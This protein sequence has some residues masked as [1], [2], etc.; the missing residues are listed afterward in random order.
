M[1]PY[2]SHR[3]L[4]MSEETTLYQ[5]I[6]ML[7]GQMVSMIQHQQTA[8]KEFSHLE[9]KLTSEI[10]KL[11]TSMQN[12][13]I[14]IEGELDRQRLKIAKLKWNITSISV[15]ATVIASFL[16]QLFFKTLK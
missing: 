8:A 11:V 5:E 13:I 15:T 14:L 9:T 1:K 7:Q 4:P 16:S 12:R 10:D 2:I 6:G 3:L